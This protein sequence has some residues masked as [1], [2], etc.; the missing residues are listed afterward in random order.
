M[1]CRLWSYLQVFLGNLKHTFRPVKLHNFVLSSWNFRECPWFHEVCWAAAFLFLLLLLLVMIPHRLKELVS[2]SA[3]QTTFPTL[4]PTSRK[5]SIEAMHI[6][7]R[8]VGFPYS[9][10]DRPWK[11]MIIVF[12]HFSAS[13]LLPL[14]S[15]PGTACNDNDDDNTSNQADVFDRAF[16]LNRPDE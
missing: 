16:L 7:L 1:W 4:P 2:T 12:R 9:S 15:T 13:Y 11:I 8:E 6:I 14:P 10:T 5:W 3:W